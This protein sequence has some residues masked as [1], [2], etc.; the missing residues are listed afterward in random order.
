MYKKIR[1]ADTPGAGETEE[2][3][4]NKIHPSYYNVETAKK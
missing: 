1:T 2:K 4:K 3:S